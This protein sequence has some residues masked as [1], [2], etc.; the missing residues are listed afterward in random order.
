MFTAPWHLYPPHP[1]SM[2]FTHLYDS[3]LT[4]GHVWFLLVP[5]ILRWR[6]F[7]LCPIQN[8]RPCLYEP[9]FVRRLE[10]L[11]RS[12]GIEPISDGPQPPVLSIKLTA[13]MYKAHNTS[14]CQLSYSR[15]RAGGRTRTYDL[16]LPKQFVYADSAFNFFCFS[17]LTFYIYYIRKLLFFQ[18]LNS[19]IFHLL[20]LYTQRFEND[21][22]RGRMG[23]PPMSL[24]QWLGR[25][26]SNPHTT[27]QTRRLWRFQRPLL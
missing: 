10:F 12:T 22:P 13:C 7:D 6:P 11:A 3:V 2:H 15:I 20:H 26:D 24:E 4:A 9:V 21:R 1:R 23:F 17:L 18:I 19:S 16:R 5:P 14:L 27:E 25:W 8:S